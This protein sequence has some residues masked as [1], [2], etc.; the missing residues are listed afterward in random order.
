M[1]ERP[2]EKL[3]QLSQRLL[4][5]SNAAS[6]DLAV[7]IAREDNILVPKLLI[8][9]PKLLDKI[10]S[11]YVFG[12][13]L[14]FA[15]KPTHYQIPIY[16]SLEKLQ[17]S[18]VALSRQSGKTMTF[19][20]G[21][22]LVA[23]TRRNVEILVISPSMRQS[24][25]LRRKM[26]KPFNL[27]HKSLKRL[28]Y[29]DILKTSITTRSGSGIFF[30]SALSEDNIRGYSAT[31]ILG[32]EIATWPN[33][34]Y[35]YD[36][37]LEPMFNTT[38]GGFMAGGTPK[39]KSGLFWK[40]RQKQDWVHIHAT[41]LDAVWAGIMTIR[42]AQEVKRKYESGEMSE[43]TMQTEYWANFFDDVGKLLSYDALMKCK[44]QDDKYVYYANIP[45]Y[46]IGGNF[47]IGTDLGKIGDHAV[48]IMLEK[49]DNY[50]CIRH[51]K[52]F[53]LG[54]PYE[55]IIKY[56]EALA[57]VFSIRGGYIDGTNNA[58][59]AE[60]IS[61]VVRGQVIKTSRPFN[62]ETA[63]ILEER[64]NIRELVLPLDKEKYYMAL[65]SIERETL[66]APKG[67][68]SGNS[69]QFDATSYAVRAAFEHRHGVIR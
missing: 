22:N 63:R 59:L 39:M 20:I 31:L 19:G 53:K 33:A 38:D 67:E 44:T 30:E 3:R 62:Q 64:V 28:L 23:L 50:Y 65:N 14:L 11:D 4:T 1:Y 66:D 43:A 36:D 57:K 60:K 41:W 2:S 26:Q 46:R 21:A 27:M 32:D 29:Q 18:T 55:K 34:E 42:R 52:V 37:V 6:I 51:I 40:L 56:H 48:V 35:L 49:I 5:E 16:R 8:Y 25:I 15:T 54:T 12:S 24:M 69:D 45:D 61:K 47:F 68:H 17:S 9:E 10:A 58:Y 7:Q 13:S